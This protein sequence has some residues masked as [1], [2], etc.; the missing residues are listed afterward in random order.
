MSYPCPC[1]NSLT[2]SQPAPGTF[3]ICPICFWEDDP[4]QFQDPNSPGGANEVSLVE[5]RMNFISLGAIDARTLRF[6]RRP[7][8]DER[9]GQSPPEMRLGDSD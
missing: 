1:C 3:E 6:V 9:P 4:V 8:S 7:A 2:L 5:A